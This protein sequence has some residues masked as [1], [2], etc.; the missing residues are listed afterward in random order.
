MNA[1]RP[2]VS[3]EFRSQGSDHWW[4]DQS[5]HYTIHNFVAWGIITIKFRKKK[6]SSNMHKYILCICYITSIHVTWNSYEYHLAK[7]QR[8]MFWW[9]IKQS[10]Q[11]TP[12]LIVMLS[13]WPTLIMHFVF[14]NFLFWSSS[15]RQ[16]NVYYSVLPLS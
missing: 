5:K 8:P 2:V 11:C 3:E 10:P 7:L 9:I 15:V 12:G 14:C 13:I 16:K 6:H 1:I 4:K